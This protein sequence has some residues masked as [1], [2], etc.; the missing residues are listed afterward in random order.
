MIQQTP[1]IKIVL[2]SFGNEFTAILPRN[3]DIDLIYR[4]FEGL[5]ISAG[6]DKEDIDEYYIEKVK[7]LNNYTNE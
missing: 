5:L 2:F 1:V 7:N 4:A 6:Y 3:I